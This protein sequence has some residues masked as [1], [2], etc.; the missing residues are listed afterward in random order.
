MTVSSQDHA[1]VGAIVANLEAAWNTADGAAFA[2]SFTDDAEFVNIFAMHI[3]GRDEIAKAHQM[4]FDSVYGGSR[5]HF[6]VAKVRR[7]SDEMM[8]AHIKTELHVPHGPMAG[9]LK[10]LATA[11]LVRD[12]SDWKIVSFHNTRQ[13]EPPARP[14]ETVADNATL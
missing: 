14:P 11:V 12:G 5:N 2:E 7:L 13:Q 10:V 4:I 3:T 9:E 8:L 1:A 6:S